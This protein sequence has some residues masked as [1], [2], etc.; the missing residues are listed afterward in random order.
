MT[1][2][3]ARY[4]TA[5]TQIDDECGAMPTSL[6]KFLDFEMLKVPEAARCLRISS[7]LVYELVAR[8]ELPAI[9]LGRKIRLP[10]FG[11]KQWIR[12]PAGLRWCK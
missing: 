3:R 9:R 11:L 1:T 10:A 4:P 7:D 2:A 5:M 8:R 6:D 12:Q